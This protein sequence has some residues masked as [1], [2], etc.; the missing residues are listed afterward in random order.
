MKIIK[1][2]LKKGLMFLAGICLSHFVNA[3]TSGVELLSMEEAVQIYINKII[4]EGESFN[5]LSDLEFYS[6]A[7]HT[8][9]PL[10]IVYGPKRVSR[11]RAM[12]GNVNINARAYQ[13]AKA[14]V[15][16]LMSGDRSQSD[17]LLLD[18][19]IDPVFFANVDNASLILDVRN[20]V[21]V[22]SCNIVGLTKVEYETTG[23]SNDGGLGLP[24]GGDLEDRGD[25]NFFA[26]FVSH[27]AEYAPNGC[28]E[29][30]TSNALIIEEEDG[31]VRPWNYDHCKI[32]IANQ[33]VSGDNVKIALLDTGLSND[34]HLFSPN[35]W[36]VNTNRTIKE[37]NTTNP[38][39][40]NGPDFCGHGTRMAGILGAPK[41]GTTVRGVAYDSDLLSVKSHLDVLIHTGYELIS[42]TSALKKIRKEK[43]G[44]EDIDIISMSAGTFVDYFFIKSEVRKITKK[45]ILF[46]AAIGTSKP[47]ADQVINLLNSQIYPA[48][49]PE[50]IG[51]TG[52]NAS[53]DGSYNANFSFKNCDNCHFGDAVNFVVPINWASYQGDKQSNKSFSLAMEGSGISECGGSSVATATMAGI[54]A[55]VKEKYPNDSAE[56]IIERL[57]LSASHGKNETA[58]FGWGVVNAAKAVG[59]D[60]DGPQIYVEIV[61]ERE[62]RRTSIFESIVSGGSGDYSY[63][64]SFG[65][66]TNDCIS[67]GNYCPTTNATLQC[68]YSF[69]EPCS[70]FMSIYL[71]V[72]DNETGSKKKAVLQ[73]NVDENIE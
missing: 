20:H 53:A 11:N 33:E 51:C 32:Q 2:I 47:A 38:L 34:Q 5:E 69:E 71:D 64:W 30:L 12:D 63:K 56:Q 48:K 65:E 46:F 19:D 10:E 28:F 60:T 3:Q 57:R 44:Y 52:V 14:N 23:A 50:T 62:L 6:I 13:I 25:N 43:P 55:L 17:V 70:G 49:Y 45:G 37:K 15:L 68:N 42:V 29:N 27:F 7:Y 36:S 61:G 1:N 59:I 4:V 41:V 8:E 18:S 40:D 21:N 9:A 58:D 66:P 67:V 35:T 24:L 22:K 26:V 39:S 73:V 72:T 31:G 16:N 54:A